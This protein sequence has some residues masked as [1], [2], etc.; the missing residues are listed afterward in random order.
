M[1]SYFNIEKSGTR[2]G[3]Y[4]GYA[5]GR[6]YRIKRIAGGSYRGWTAY[7]ANDPYL[8]YHM[9]FSLA[10]TTLGILSGKLKALPHIKHDMEMASHPAEQAAIAQL[11]KD[12]I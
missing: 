3:E 10:G 6:V 1:R 2:R 7:R 11:K 9:N 12:S 4:V 8:E 5:G